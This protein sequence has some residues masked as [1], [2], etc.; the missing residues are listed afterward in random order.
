MQRVFFKG[1]NSIEK[2]L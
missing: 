2:T 1:A